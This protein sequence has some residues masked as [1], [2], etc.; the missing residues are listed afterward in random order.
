MGWGEEGEGEGWVVKFVDEEDGA[1]EDTWVKGQEIVSG[2]C[3]CDCGNKTLGG[4]GNHGNKTPTTRPRKRVS[5]GLHKNEIF[6]P[7]Q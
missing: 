4:D 1:T 5:F 6:T 7:Q 3:E 2:G